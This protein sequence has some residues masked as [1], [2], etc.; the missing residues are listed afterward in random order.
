MADTISFAATSARHGLPLIFPGQVQKEFFVNEAHALIDALLH[1][2]LLGT[3]TSPPSN[4]QDGDCWIVG[5]GATGEWAGRANMLACRQAG[6]WLYAKPCEGLKAYDRKTG[7]ELRY[8]NGRWSGAVAVTKVQ[9]GATVDAEARSAI[10]GLIAALTHAGILPA[11]D[12]A[13]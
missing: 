10:A 5:A 2:V 8:S 12:Q 9:G 7:Q 6:T 3:A 4:M 11:A 13:A 1:P